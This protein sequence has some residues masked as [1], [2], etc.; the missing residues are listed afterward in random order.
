MKNA[1]VVAEFLADHPKVRQ[2]HYLGFLAPSPL[3][4]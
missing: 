3:E 1:R 4:P 2:V